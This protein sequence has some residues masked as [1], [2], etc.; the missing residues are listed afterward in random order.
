MKSAVRHPIL[1]LLLLAVLLTGVALPADENPPV[2]FRKDVAPLLQRRC[3]S[4]HGEDSAKGGYRLDTF[5]R[6]REPGDGGDATVVAGNS[7]ASSIFK[8]LTEKDPDDRMPQKADALPAEEI[9]LIKRW[10]DSGAVYD[11]GN[12]SR[13]LAE[14]VRERH[15]RPAPAHYA[16]PM[17]ITALAF[18][19]DGRRIASNGYHELLVWDSATGT[20]A[21][22]IG[23]M[24]ERIHSLAWHPKRN[25]LAVGGGTP[26]QWGTV[27]LVDASR[28]YAVRLLC[29]LP[30]V[31]L[32]VA[33][34]KDGST[35]V[36]GCGDRTMR[37]FDVS[38]G[39]EK[40]V[41][42]QHSDWVQ[43]VA[44]NAGGTLLVSAS[45]DRT[46]AVFD[47]A[48]WE[49]EATFR[50]HETSLLAAAFSSDGSRVITSG[51]GRILVWNSEKANTRGSLDDLGGEARA[52]AAGLF[53]IAAGCDDGAVRLYQTDSGKPWLTLR[54][55]RDAVQALSVSPKGDV[56]ASGAADG[57]IILWTALCWEP[58]VRILA[59]P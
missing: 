56:L 21:R 35:L 8:L 36:A 44:F 39:K 2:S 59:R 3:A 57:E 55:H 31:A 7:R 26:G 30:E 49:Q 51:R 13:P 10:L 54:A 48:T 16:R 28:G 23:G 18:S 58:A 24:P 41:L 50:E 43:S 25:I 22:R 9:A 47:A 15:L 4:C 12:P 29:D 42:R 37:I 27:A 32:G 17:P 38:A 20:L 14:L 19:G 5:A 6:L 34:D 46:A 40:R 11:G 53:G 1:H 45:R 33:F 52:L